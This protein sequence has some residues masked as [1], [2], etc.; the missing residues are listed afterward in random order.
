MM[1][2]DF[3]KLKACIIAKG[4]SVKGLGEE[5]GV[6]GSYISAVIGGRVIPKS[7]MVAKM[8][9]VLKCYPSEIMEF[10][11]ISVDERF[12]SKDKRVP[13]T[14]GKELSYGPL[15]YF[16]LEYK[17]THPERD[18]KWIFDLIKTETKVNEK[19]AE[20][21][22]ESRK[23]RYGV[24]KEKETVGLNKAIRTK[25]RKNRPLNLEII[26]AICKSLRCTADF[27]IGCK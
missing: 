17:K 24:E 10:E 20:A 18:A 13:L 4:M 12:F 15:W 23:E 25:L 7:D 22:R 21:L 1:K 3:K 5:I 11:G 19:A 6:R 8:C 26:Y 14:G 9:G 16:I 27:V 2:V